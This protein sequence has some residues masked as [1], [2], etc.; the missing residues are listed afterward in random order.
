MLRI[1]FRLHTWFLVP[2]IADK[3]NKG[4]STLTN[5]QQQIE[6]STRKEIHAKIKTKYFRNTARV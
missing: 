2:N 1:V 6:R 4:N 3:L 5:N